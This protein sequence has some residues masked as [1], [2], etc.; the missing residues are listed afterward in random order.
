MVP[1]R[2][3][4]SIALM[5]AHTLM[6]IRPDLQLLPDTCT[7]AHVLELSADNDT[8]YLA[9]EGDHSTPGTLVTI[10]VPPFAVTR[11][12]SIGVFPDSVRVVP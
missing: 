6:P 2:E 8:A 9:C 7:N 4:G 5:D 10:A 11:V 1:I 3:T 12:T